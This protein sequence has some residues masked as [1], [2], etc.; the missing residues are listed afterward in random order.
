MALSIFNLHPKF[1]TAYTGK[2]RD[3][4]GSIHQRQR[5]TSAYIHKGFFVFIKGIKPYLY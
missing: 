2:G 3:D 1:T 5:I 4:M